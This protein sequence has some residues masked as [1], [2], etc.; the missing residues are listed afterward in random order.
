MTESRQVEPIK[1]AQFNFL[2]F[3]WKELSAIRES[4]R[5]GKY[6][7]AYKNLTDQI[8]WMPEDFQN[9]FEFLKETRENLRKLEAI[10]SDNPMFQRRQI[11]TDQ[12]K[13]MMAKQMLED[14]VPKFAI[15]LD[16]KGY[17]EKHGYPVEH[18]SE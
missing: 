6:F 8:M 4:Q 18:G 12:T 10:N 14:F 7:T 15:K 11:D 9:K 5:E 3:L 13:N 2:S 16:Q 1:E 17:M